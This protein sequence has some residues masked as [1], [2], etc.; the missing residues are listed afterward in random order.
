MIRRGKGTV[1]ELNAQ[2]EFILLA[3]RIWAQPQACSTQ[4]K[5]VRECH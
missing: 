4:L 2:L 1:G 3:N 5:I